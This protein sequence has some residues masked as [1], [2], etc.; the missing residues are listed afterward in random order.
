MLWV[1]GVPRWL[2]A[3]PGG[4]TN[5]YAVTEG[6]FVLGSTGTA[7]GVEYWIYSASTDSYRTLQV[8]D[9]FH[10]SG[11]VDMNV[12][13]DIVGNAWDETRSSTLPFVWPAGGQPRLLPR[14]AG[15]TAGYVADIADDGRIL[16]QLGK[17]DGTAYGNYLWPSR[18][19]RPA[20]LST[21]DQPGVWA[22]TL[23]GSRI[24]GGFGVETDS[25]GLLWN[26]RTGR[27]TELEDGVADLNPSGDLVTHGG[28]IIDRWPSVLIRSDG[29]RITFPAETYFWHIFDRNDPHWTAAGYELVDNSPQ[30][31]AY[32]CAS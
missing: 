32:T 19:R 17:Q 30:A 10:I 22:R 28:N 20:R 23:E 1:D 11:L 31:I 26:T 15:F 18:N 7:T 2:T 14:P 21:P 27:Y 16:G 12:H 13:Q 9:N 3:R 4:Y 5:A 25:R 6:G 24:A 29:T 8:P